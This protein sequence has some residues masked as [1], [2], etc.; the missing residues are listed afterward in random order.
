MTEPSSLSRSAANW[1]A[2]P[3]RRLS[4]P[5]V[6]QTSSHRLRSGDARQAQRSEVSAQGGGRVWPRRKAIDG[7]RWRSVAEVGVRG[8]SRCRGRLS[9]PS[10]G[11]TRPLSGGERVR[12]RIVSL[13]LSGFTVHACSCCRDGSSAEVPTGQ[14]WSVAH[15]RAVSITAYA[16][17]IRSRWPLPAGRASY[18]DRR[19]T[20]ARKR[21]HH[22]CTVMS[23]RF[24]RGWPCLQ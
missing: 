4:M 21:R 16:N 11:Q 2:S 10:C 24:A 8:R 13:E 14:M 17:V 3:R 22:G 9:S 5:P 7:C 6:R 23:P 15:E 18:G 20:R 19:P 12:P 1:T